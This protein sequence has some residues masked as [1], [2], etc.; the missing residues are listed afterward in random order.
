MLYKCWLL[1][2]AY[3][4]MCAHGSVLVVFPVPGRSHTTLGDAVVRSL[5]K[6]GHNVSGREQILINTKLKK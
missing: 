5:L 1:L 4:H 2:S 3:L 6:G